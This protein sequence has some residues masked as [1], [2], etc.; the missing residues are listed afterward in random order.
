MHGGEGISMVLFLEKNY[1][2]YRGDK[3]V[4]I[5]GGGEVG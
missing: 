3:G 2:V 1:G 4:I 5:P